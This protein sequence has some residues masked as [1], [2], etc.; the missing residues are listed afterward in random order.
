MN[1]SSSLAHACEQLSRARQGSLVVCSPAE[2]GVIEQLSMSDEPFVKV[3]LAG[4]DRLLLGPS[5]APVVRAACAACA[6][7][8]RQVAHG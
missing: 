6:V 7:N 2:Y 3:P 4:T 5:C 8:D 1:T